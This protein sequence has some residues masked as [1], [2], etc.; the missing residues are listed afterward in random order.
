[1]E[2]SL[3]LECSAGVSGDMLVAALLDAGASQEELMCVLDSLPVQGF[4]IETT[5]VKKSGLDVCDFNVVLDAEHDGHDHDMEYLYGHLGGAAAVNEVAAAENA[6]YGH[7]HARGSEHIHT[8]GAGHEHVNEHKH[9]A[10]RAAEHNHEHANTHA[11]SHEHRG[12]HEI[13]AIIEASCATHGAKTI[14]R[15]TFEIL[16]QAEA[17]AHGVSVEEVHFHEV[18]AVDSIVDIIAASV[19]LDNLTPQ[20]VYVPKLC[21]GHGSVR[22]QH[23]ILPVPVPAVANIA[24]ACSIP[25]SIINVQGELVTPTGAAFTAAVRTKAQLPKAFT[26][27]RTGLGAGKRTYP[28]TSGLL[29]AFVIES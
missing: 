21:E 28:E 19:C 25:L 23:G 27:K 11:H 14:A 24:Q 29:R 3:Y 12:L 5:R 2:Q 1:M 16:A 7:V 4:S 10:E 18:G 9:V 17:K 22:C 8:C 20:N 6:E 26:I 15:R 13:L